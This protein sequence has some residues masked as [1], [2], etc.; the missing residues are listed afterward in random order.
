MTTPFR[1]SFLGCSGR[2]EVST[3]DKGAET[4][5]KV[6]TVPF[7]LLGLDLP[8]PPLFKDP[9]EKNI[10]P[11]VLPQLH[12]PETSFYLLNYLLS[13]HLLHFL[14]FSHVLPSG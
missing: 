10:I 12:K 9:L 4:P 13:L 5:S 8:P 3:Y 1:S 14:F 2:L 11:Q 7:W 6:V